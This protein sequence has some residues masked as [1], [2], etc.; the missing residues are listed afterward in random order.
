MIFLRWGVIFGIGVSERR[1]SEPHQKASGQGL[2]CLDSL[3]QDILRIVTGSDPQ[4]GIEC[5]TT[6]KAGGG[7]GIDR[8]Q[9]SL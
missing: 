1:L 3:R 2:E 8:F 4:R 7:F 9:N 5:C 6:E